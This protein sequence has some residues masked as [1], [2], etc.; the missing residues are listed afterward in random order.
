MAHDKMYPNDGFRFSLTRM[1]SMMPMVAKDLWFSFD[2]NASAV[3]S[4][5]VIS[6]VHTVGFMAD[7][8]HGIEAA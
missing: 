5:H 4:E 6:K 2:F 7:K 1:P 8:E 3:K